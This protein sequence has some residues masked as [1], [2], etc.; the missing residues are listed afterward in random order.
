MHYI[1]T[2]LLC[3]TIVPLLLQSLMPLFVWLSTLYNSQYA[4]L[5][6]TAHCKLC[7]IWMHNVFLCG[8]SLIVHNVNG[9]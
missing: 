1:L 7:Y 6:V 3:V 8:N 5:R 9:A 4:M 2:F